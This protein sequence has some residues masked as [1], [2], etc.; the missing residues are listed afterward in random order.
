MA[1]TPQAFG[2]RRSIHQF[3]VSGSPVASSL[4]NE[5]QWPSPLMFSLGIEPSMTSTNG[6]SSSSRSAWRNGLRNSSPPRGGDRTLLWRLTFGRPGIAPRS[7][8]S[9]LGWP[10]AVTDTES[11]SQLIPSEIQRMSTSSTAGA[12]GSVAMG[13]LHHRQRVHEQLLPADQLELEAS[14]ACVRER[15]AGQLALRPAFPADAGRGH[16]LQHELRPLGLRALGHEGEG[17]R[18]RVG[19]DLAQVAD[20]DLDGLD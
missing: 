4:P 13:H 2:A 14:A 8:S 19:H 10:A 6:A 18:Q 17:E 5:V 9:M 16:Q 15:E 11:P 20:L 12:C 7:T 1:T 3:S